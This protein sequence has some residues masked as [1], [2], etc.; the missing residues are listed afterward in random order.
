MNILDLPDDIL[1]QIFKKY[2]NFSDLFSLSSCC[3]R[4]LNLL[5]KY[6]IWVTYLNKLPLLDYN[7]PYGKI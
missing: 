1:I 4:F 2:L 6:N 5:N 3:T 7:Y